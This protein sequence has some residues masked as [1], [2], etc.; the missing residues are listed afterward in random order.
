MVLF[1]NDQFTG[2]RHHRHLRRSAELLRE[3]ATPAP[4]HFLHR[5]DNKVSV[6]AQCLWT[7]IRGSLRQGRV[8]SCA[9]FRK[10]VRRP[11]FRRELLRNLSLDGTRMV[12]A[13][14]YFQ[15]EFRLGDNSLGYLL[16]EGCKTLW[17][18]AEDVFRFPT[19]KV[20]CCLV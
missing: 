13:L 19:V 6:V 17:P 1:Q 15:C 18:V 20:A 14:N 11:V 10:R 12:K 16:T 8:C 4:S 5:T 3:F 7:H 9:P 2:R